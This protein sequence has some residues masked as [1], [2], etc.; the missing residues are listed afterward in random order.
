MNEW[1]GWK[2]KDTNRVY[3]SMDER[4]AKGEKEK[5]RERKRQ[6]IDGC[7]INSGNRAI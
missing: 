2:K 1:E 4:E 3:M 6:T 7:H 5:R